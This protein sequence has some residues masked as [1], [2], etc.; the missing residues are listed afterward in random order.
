MTRLD[1]TRQDLW[2][3]LQPGAHDTEVEDLVVN[4]QRQLEDVEDG[5]EV[6]YP[7]LNIVRH[8]AHHKEEQ[9]LLSLHGVE[10]EPVL[11]PEHQALLA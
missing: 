6:V 5:L 7:G 10:V 1:I 8:V 2:R 4:Q 3:P 11:V 9:L